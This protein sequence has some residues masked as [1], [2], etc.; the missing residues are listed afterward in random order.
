[1]LSSLPKDI[2][3]DILLNLPVGDVQKLASTDSNLNSML[4]NNKSFWR[5][6]FEQDYSENADKA[7]NWLDKYKNN[8]FSYMLGYRL[9]MTYFDSPIHKLA[10]GTPLHISAGYTH[11]VVLDTENNVWVFGDN[12]EGQLGLGKA[13]KD[14]DGQKLP[15]IKAKEVATGKYHTLLIDMDDNVWVFGDNRT[16]QLGIWGWRDLWYVPFKQYFAKTPEYIYTPI[17]LN[18]KASAVTSGEFHS[19]VVDLND[20]IWVF[21]GNKGGQLGLNDTRERAYPTRLTGLKGKKVF[22]C[23]DGTFIID[24]EDELWCCGTNRW[25]ILG[26]ESKSKQLVPVKLGIKAKNIFSNRGDY[27]Q[28]ILID[29]ENNMWACGGNMYDIFSNRTFTRIEGPK[30]KSVSIGS[31]HMLFI[32]LNNNLWVYGK[33]DCGAL[34]QDIKKLR[35]FEQF[36]MIPNIKVKEISSSTASSAIIGYVHE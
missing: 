24:D 29:F 35:R 11:I 9:G 10:C 25:G 36:T 2:V 15:G 26:L 27:S 22:A 12:T 7:D 14:S 32:D 18:L 28:S 16:H 21:G 6:R 31:L 33:N 1:M 13:V 8:V 3:G 30:V 34:G 4:Q 17:K 19:V 20:D 23:R 5:K